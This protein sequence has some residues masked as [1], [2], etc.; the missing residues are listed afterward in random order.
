M[1]KDRRLSLSSEERAAKSELILANLNNAI[2]WSGM[3]AI[4]IFEPMLDLGEVDISKFAGEGS[5]FTSRKIDNRWQVVSLKGNAPVP[6]QFDVVIVPMLGFDPS[7]HRIG[8]GG[9]FYDRF[10]ATQPHAKK[11]G[12]CFEVGHVASLP[13]EPHDI[14]LDLILTEA[15]IYKNLQ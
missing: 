3:K 15:E 9:G 4:H 12:V 5:L 11:I 1:L 7:L 2:D 13:V 10:L 8:Y 14:S 6:D